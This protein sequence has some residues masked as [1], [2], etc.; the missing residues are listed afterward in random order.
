MDTE[1]VVLGGE[2]V[3]VS[4]LVA[5]VVGDLAAIRAR[6]SALKAA[7]LDVR[8]IDHAVGWLVEDGLRAPYTLTEKGQQAIG[9][10]V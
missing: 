5:E 7:G 10:G 4:S 2:V 3:E 8:P 9:R 6:R 1:S